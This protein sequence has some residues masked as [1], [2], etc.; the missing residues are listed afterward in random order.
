MNYFLVF[1]NKSF[2]KERNGGF[3]WA[4]QKNSKEQIFHHWTDM[5]MIRKG[6]IN[7]N[8]FKGKLVS[9]LVAKEDHK[10]HDK[11]IGLE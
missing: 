2:K 8:S 3:L 5:K 11:P 9:I 1:Q 7:F 4:P 10:V 6:D